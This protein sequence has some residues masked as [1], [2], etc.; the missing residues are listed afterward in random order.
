MKKLLLLLLIFPFIGSSTLEKNY[1]S[2]SDNITSIIKDSDFRGV[3]ESEFGNTIIWVDENKKYNYL[4][5]DN[6]HDI[7]K[8]LS[9]ELIGNKLRVETIFLEANW[10]STKI[11]SL[12][13]EE[14][15]VVEGINDNGSYEQTLNRIF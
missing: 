11:L 9:V 8:T 5:M 12:M 4:Y 13:N 3:W 1:K 2:N 6:S 7:T 14:T 15:I 10:R